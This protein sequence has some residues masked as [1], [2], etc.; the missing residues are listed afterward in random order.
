MATE[1]AARPGRRA[2]W[3][4][5]FA[6]VGLLAAIFLLDWFGP[7]SAI[8]TSF[9]EAEQIQEQFGGPD[10]VM[11]D[12]EDN[13]WQALG[14]GR[15]ILLAAAL[16]GIG[17]TFVRLAQT[18]PFT[19]LRAAALATALGTVATAVVLYQL[20]NPPDD[21]SREIGVYAGLVAAGAVA[22]SAWVALKDE[23]LR[24]GRGAPRARPNTRDVA[25]R[26]EVSPEAGPPARERSSRRKRSRSSS[27]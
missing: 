11:P 27:D 17:L 2:L 5:M 9:D 21:S 24:T 3:L 20:A 6:G 14:L 26:R 23:E 19:R 12:V 7:S 15:F 10:V 25:P 1:R 8:S 18:P 4:A 16:S 22:L 13:A